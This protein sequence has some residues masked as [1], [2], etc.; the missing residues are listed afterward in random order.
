M[1]AE[2]PSGQ[3][4]SDLLLLSYHWTLSSLPQAGKLRLRA[5]VPPAGP[6]LVLSR[7]PQPT[8]GPEPQPA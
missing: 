3:T 2:N 7:C 4:I 1:A 6:G 8:P 5:T